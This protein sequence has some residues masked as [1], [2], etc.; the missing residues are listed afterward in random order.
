[1]PDSPR[2]WLQ[3]V[4]AGH[5]ME[6]RWRT[7]V[8]ETVDIYTGR[9]VKAMSI[10]QRDD[11]QYNILFANTQVLQSAIYSNEP[12]PDVRR[13]YR[14]SDP[15][16]RVISEALE[17]AL[18][19]SID[20][21]RWAEM[22]DYMRMDYILAGRSVVRVRYEPKFKP[23][24]QDEPQLVWQTVTAEAWPYEDFARSPHTRWDNVE[25]IAFRHWM[26]KKDA[27]KEFSVEF[28]MAQK[29]G[30]QGGSVPKD[31]A[32]QAAH[33]LEVWEIWDKKHRM[34]YWIS[35]EDQ[36]KYLREMEDPLRLMGFFPIPPPLYSIP[37][38]DSLIPVPEYTIY[39]DLAF[40][41]QT[42]TDRINRI[43]RSIRV[44]GVYDGSINELGR[45]FEAPDTDMIASDNVA[46]LR[47][48]GGLQ[49]AVWMY[50]NRT[51]AETLGILSQYR[52][53]LLQAIYEVTGISDIIR[54]A[55]RPSETATAQNL[56]A[57]YG[58]LRIEPR[59][60]SVARFLRDILRLWAE[61]ICE[62]FTAET[63]QQMTGLELPDP[64][65]W[66]E[67]I[68]AMRNEVQLSYRIDIETDSTIADLTLADQGMLNELLQA[69]GS[70][71]QTMAPLV[72]A[73]AIPPQVG[74]TLLMSVVR[75]AKLGA[76]VEDAID[77]MMAQ[78][79]PTGMAEEKP[80]EIP[81]EMM[82]QIQA[83]QQRLQEQE[84][85]IQMGM[86]KLQE[87][88]QMIGQLQA[89]LADKVADRAL[90]A[91]EVETHRMDV[92]VKASEATAAVQ[93]MAAETAKITIETMRMQQPEMPPPAVGPDPQLMAAVE[94]LSQMVQASAARAATPPPPINITVPEPS[95][96]VNISRNG[97]MER[98]PIRSPQGLIERVIEREIE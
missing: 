7:T 43:E 10:Y 67:V 72:Q 38:P 60:V 23:A 55:S 96:A 4:R 63:M 36:S 8:A 62:H 52:D 84:Q 42:L 41:L 54:G 66:E 94:N 97:A 12:R 75:R 69:V 32:A 64:R 19:Y 26:P 50:D 81:P 29:A 27:E 28:P 61:I 15:I 86:Q 74:Q 98:I 9:D 56:K 48:V 40:E 68:F 37:Q 47:Q 90:K 39:R 30:T 25:W 82:E 18:S 87:Q 73:G 93:K 91:A 77:Q 83:G 6:E 44:R 80:P 51:A 79:D 3:A 31:A 49:G 24:D 13:R 65:I 70:F 53:R 59:Q 89:E 76:Q 85:M 45:L 88:A 35:E 71:T 46:K 33:S 11:I 95:I 17:R 21:M 92:Q 34:V 22:I 5:S 14:D 16:A 20:T 58:S 2:E 78:T 57:R 1:M